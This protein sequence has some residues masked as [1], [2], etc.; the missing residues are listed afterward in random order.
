MGL[1]DFLSGS[2]SGAPAGNASVKKYASRVLDKRGQ[3]PER[4]DAIHALAKLR[5][6]EAVEALLPRFGFYTDPS[7]TDQ[8]EKDAAFEGIVATGEPALAPIRAYLRATGAINWPIRMLERLLTPEQVVGELLE[9]LEGLDTE[10]ARDPA[11]KLELLAALEDRKDA[12]IVAAISRFL[13]D[14]NETVRFSVV[15]AIFAQD[16]A[17]QAQSALAA[18]AAKEESL[19]VRNRI[20][21]G[22]RA[23]GWNA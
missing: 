2:K 18:L 21:E 9:V 13:E 11:K 23:R 8:E 7:I 14:V 17:D 19:R 20:T 3:S 16:N 4:F 6:T 12:R 1:F 15:G 22:F 5:T 10:Y